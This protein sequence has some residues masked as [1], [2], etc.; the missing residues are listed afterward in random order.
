MKL[1]IGLALAASAALFSV[2]P[3]EAKS[4]PQ[5]VRLLYFIANDE[6][7]GYVDF[8]NLHRSGKVIRGWALNVFT[9]AKTLDG[10]DEPV[11]SY[12]EN[13]GGDCKGNTVYSYGI[14]LLDANDAML[15]DVDPNT[16]TVK[17]DVR[18]GSFDELC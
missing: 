4:P 18:P 12:W 2:V 8:A 17:R 9:P 1:P 10:A 5:S 6:Q 13:F 15:F 11:G 3:A 14:A 7:V 16:K